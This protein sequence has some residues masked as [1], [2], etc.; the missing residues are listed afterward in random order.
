MCALSFAL[1]TFYLNLHFLRVKITIFF[2]FA[3]D[4]MVFI[5]N[6]LV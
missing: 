5:N 6:I 4:T 1:S 3:D 2:I